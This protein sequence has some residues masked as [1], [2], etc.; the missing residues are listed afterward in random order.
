MASSTLGR[1][2]E[3]L[4]PGKR[5]TAA[6]MQGAP[7]GDRIREV[8]V[9]SI[10]PNPHQPREAIAHGTLEELTSSI[11]EHG[12]IQPLVVVVEG[13]GY[14]L[15]AGERRLR[16]A[17]VLGLKQV[18][19]VIRTATEQQQL[20][21][22]IVENVQRVNLNPIE[23]ANGYQRLMEEFTLTQEEVAQKVGQS[24]SAVANAL[25]LLTLPPEMQRALQEEKMTE[26]HAKVLLGVQSATERTRIFNEIVKNS[27]SVRRTEAQAKTVSVRRHIRRVSQDPNLAE[28]ENNLQAVLGTKVEIR[29]KGDQGTVTIHYYSPEELQEIIRT[30]AK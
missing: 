28:K 15:I 16:A 11:K 23:K 20:E 2:L 9:M 10:H 8:P 30:I 6:S 27:L 4:I 24:R 1:G 5:G 12:I 13:D 26:G 21:L 7:S 22:A 25:R 3:S 17:K 18:P 29:Q 14:Q 19:V